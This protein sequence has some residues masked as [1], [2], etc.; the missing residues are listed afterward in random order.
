MFIPAFFGDAA[1]LRG[2]MPNSDGDFYWN[3]GWPMGNFEVN[4]NEDAY[5]ISK[6]NGKLY[7]TGVSPAFFTHYGANTWNKNWIYRSDDWLYAKRWE[8]L[9]S[10]RNEVNIVQITTW[11]GASSFLF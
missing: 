10:H 4:W 9:V 5:H 11:N 6:N 7:M 2:L 3:G 8:Q 1:N